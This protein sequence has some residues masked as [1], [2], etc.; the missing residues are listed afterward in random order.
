MKKTIILILLLLF[1]Y[2]ANA[3]SKRTIKDSF[4]TTGFSGR[5]T[6]RI[7]ARQV[8]KMVIWS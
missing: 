6:M 8:F 3:Q 2:A 4:K 5:S 7:P 1:V